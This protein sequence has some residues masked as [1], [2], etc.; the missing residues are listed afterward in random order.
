MIKKF[1]I[2][3]FMLGLIYILIPGPSSIDDFSPIPDSL[4]SNEPGD[5][6]QNP[7]ITAYFS[8]YDRAKITNHYKDDFA[9]KFLFG[10]L[11]PPTTLNYPPR[12]AYVKIRDQLYVTFL[13]EYSYPLKGSIYVGGYEPVIQNDIEHMIHNFVGDHIHINDRYFNSKT[14]I[15]FY[16]AHWYYSLPIYLGLWIVGIC[17]FKLFKR[18]FNDE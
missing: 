5:T 10:K 4:K 13:E 18:V 1:L 3:F 9:G 7:N 8:D 14:T 2:G 11:I 16:P 15:R 6:V 12:D 17:L